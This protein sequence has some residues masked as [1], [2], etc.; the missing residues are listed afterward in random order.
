MTSSGS[1]YDASPKGGSTNNDVKIFQYIKIEIKGRRYFCLQQSLFDL[2]WILYFKKDHFFPIW[3]SDLNA[4]SLRAI[5]RGM[6][7][8]FVVFR[9]I[10]RFLLDFSCYKYKLRKID[11]VLK[12]SSYGQI[13][14]HVHKGYKFFDFRKRVV[15]KVFDH[16]VSN[17]VILKEI[18]N[19]N[20]VS[21]IDFAPSIGRWNIEERWYEED[22]IDGCLDPS[23]KSMDSALF[24]K[25]FR[26]EVVQYMNSLVLF[27]KPIVKN[28]VEYVK[29]VIKTLDVTGYT[30]P[31]QHL[32]EF[33]EIT[34]FINSLVERLHSEGNY[35]I[36]LVFSHGDF[37]P[38]NML[39][40]SQGI[41]LVDWEEASSRSAS[42][43]FY[44]YFFLS[45]HF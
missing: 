5:F 12:F 29:D 24:L 22:Y 17:S 42:F 1:T 11:S 34:S 35:P 14:M 7:Q 21:G 43:D 25:N 30:R 45:P 32:K 26:C 39:K 38:A 31:N 2:S 9:T 33:S 28:S 13:C 36:Q 15:R 8:K 19:L 18:E 6:R 41:K 16:D 40:T 20:R 44:S 4:L 3:Q 37:V 27:Q 10:L 23:Y